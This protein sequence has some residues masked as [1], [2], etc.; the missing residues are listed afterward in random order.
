MS[1]ARAAGGEDAFFRTVRYCSIRTPTERL[2]RL[3]IV[4]SIP[5]DPL[6]PAFENV[7]RVAPAKPEAGAIFL[8]VNGLTVIGAERFRRRAHVRGASRRARPGWRLRL[9]GLGRARD[10]AGD[11]QRCA[12]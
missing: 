7:A 8:M 6:G 3:I 2:A 9:G 11:G 1:S 4:A 5:T 12:T 10:V